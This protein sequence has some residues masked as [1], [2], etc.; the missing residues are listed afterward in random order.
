MFPDFA[1]PYIAEWYNGERQCSQRFASLSQAE[2]FLR[3]NFPN[4]R[5]RGYFRPV[6]YTRAYIDIDWTPCLS[7]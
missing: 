7:K 4:P 2:A 3:A 1:Y 5:D 6:L